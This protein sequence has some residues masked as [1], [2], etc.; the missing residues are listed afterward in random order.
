MYQQY[1]GLTEQPFSIAVNPRYLFMSDRHR[2]ALAHL[3]YGVGSGGGFIL[4]T[5]EVGTGKTTLNRCLL[6]QLPEQTDIAIVLNPA[7]SAVELLATVCDEFEVEYEQGTDSLKLLTDALHQF[8]LANHRANRRTV[9]MIDEAQHLGFE[10]LEQIRLLTNL[11]TDERKLLQIILTGQPEL[12]DML[13]RPELRQLNQRITA[14][15]NL[16]PL[17]ASETAAYIQHRLQIAGLPSN[18]VVF[19]S[20]ASKAVYRLSGGVPRLVNLLCDRAMMGAYGRQV[21]EVSA[22]LVTEAAAEVLGT[23]SSNVT[24]PDRAG[25]R[26]GRLLIV[27]LALLCG[28]VWFVTKPN[29]SLSFTSEASLA[30]EEDTGGTK[31]SQ[32]DLRIVSPDSPASAAGVGAA[33]AV[34][35]RPWLLSPEQAERALWGL[36]QGQPLVE[37]LCDAASAAGWLCERHQADVWDAVLDHNR[38]SIL[39]LRRDNGFA[40]AAVLLGISNET[41]QLWTGVAVCEVPVAALAA[42]WRGRFSYLWQTPTGWTGPVSEG[43]TGIVVTDIVRALSVLDGL[44]VPPL[45]VYTAAVAERVRTFQRARGLEIDGVMGAR[46]WRAL[47]D[48]IGEG[49]SLENALL[50]ALSQ[51]GGAS[52]L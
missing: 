20:A 31:M 19:P 10:V 15:F 1:F 29:F 39:E 50:S 26:Y 2:D 32:P 13:K 35:V 3:L 48:E 25:M 45:T 38:P 49:F 33:S 4:L 12:A 18:R 34:A 43:A 22:R 41:A 37:G 24:D 8:L 7:L 5:G 36:V 21:E 9:L 42:L 28:V 47:S 52:C 51:S 17:D 27:T 40:G 6:E 14:R 16:T 23:V 30:E 44:P 46:S 11:E